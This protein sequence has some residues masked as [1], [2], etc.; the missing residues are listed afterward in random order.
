MPLSDPHTDAVTSRH[1]LICKPKPLTARGMVK[2]LTE[3]AELSGNASQNKKKDKVK[4]MLV[5]AQVTD[6]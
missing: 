1:S 2:T 3:I 4:Q 6:D 5:A